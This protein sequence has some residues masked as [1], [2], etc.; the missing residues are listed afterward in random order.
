MAVTDIAGKKKA[1]QVYLDKIK[2]GIGSINDQHTLDR[3]LSLLM[4]VDTSCRVINNDVNIKDFEKKDTFAPAQKN[5]TQ[6]RFK[7]TCANPGRKKKNIPFR[8]VSFNSISIV[9]NV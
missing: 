2:N 8:Y 7:K 4:Q 5:E 3:I 1:I 9:S 6:L